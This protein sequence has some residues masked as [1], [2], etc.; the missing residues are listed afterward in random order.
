MYL[1]NIIALYGDMRHPP[2][3]EVLTMAGR[4]EGLSDP[5]WFIFSDLF[6]NSGKRG[7]GM[8]RVPV[9]QA[10]NSILYIL[11]TGSRWCDLPEGPDWAHRSSAHRCLKRWGLDGTLFLIMQKIFTLAQKKGLID[12]SAGSVDGSFSPWQRRGSRR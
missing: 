11:I 3:S 4:F 6:Q 5:E 9:R 1:T 10:L 2:W 8:P 7:R 12:W